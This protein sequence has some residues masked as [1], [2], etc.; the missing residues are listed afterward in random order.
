MVALRYYRELLF[1]IPDWNCPLTAQQ[2]AAPYCVAL[3]EFIDEKDRFNED[4]WY[5]Q[6]QKNYLYV[7]VQGLRPQQ[8][9][10]CISTNSTFCAVLLQT[11]SHSQAKSIVQ[12]FFFI[13][14]ITC[15]LRI[16]LSD[17]QEYV[18][19]I[20]D[21]Y[22]QALQLMEYRHLLTN[23][24]LITSDMVQDFC[25]SNYYYPM[26]TE[27]RLILL[28]VSGNGEAISLF[29]SLVEQNTKE[30]TLSPN[31][32]RSL[33]FAFIGTLV[34]AFEELKTTPEELLG[35]T[36]DFSGLYAD[37]ANQKI[38]ASLRQMIC[39]FVEAVE[40]RQQNS[41][42]DLL[43][44]M[45]DFIYA[46]Y[47]DDIMLNDVAQHCGVSASYCSTLF[48]R[49]SCDNFKTFLN[50]YRIEQACRFL[51]ENPHRK[52]SDL[53]QMVGFNS[54]SSFIRVFQRLMGTSP[55]AYAESLLHPSH[56]D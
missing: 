18:M 27:S 1:T 8:N 56:K 47:S 48:K 54:S 40:K 13:P 36:I 42:D 11:A 22:Q 4:D 23:A 31:S 32:Y 12:E 26:S 20:K 41:E 30:R 39:A 17:V 35:Y 51:Q 46:N 24:P 52:I 38:F 29:D 5:L 49:L 45:L 2:M 28:M 6:L 25:Q 53:S 55:K 16:A 50:R 3:V 7:H 44:S 37:A 34:R 10:Y 33:S 19:H 14:T 9:A 15:R 21:C 43:Q